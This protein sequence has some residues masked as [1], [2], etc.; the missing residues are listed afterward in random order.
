MTTVP[1]TILITGGSKGLGLNAACQLAAKGANV[2]VVARGQ[3]SLE[4][5]VTSV[6]VFIAQP[7][8]SICHLICCRK[9]LA[10]Q[11]SDSILLAPM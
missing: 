10:P 8:F 4:D 2:I 11:I 7:R 5:A 1:Q 9:V 6:S 3:K